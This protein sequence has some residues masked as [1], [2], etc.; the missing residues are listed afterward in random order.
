M[1]NILNM[2]DAMLIIIRDFNIKFQIVVQRYIDLSIKK[3]LLIPWKSVYLD[4]VKYDSP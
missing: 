2:L 3:Y 4:V 1:F